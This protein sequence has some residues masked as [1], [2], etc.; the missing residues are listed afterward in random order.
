MALITHEK[1]ENKN[2]LVV[3]A[4][5]AWCELYDM[6]KKKK[7]MAIHCILVPF[8]CPNLYDMKELQ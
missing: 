1:K 3:W 6:K 8:L 7:K 2:V 5:L 4:Q